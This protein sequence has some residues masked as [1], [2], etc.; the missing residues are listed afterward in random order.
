MA[1]TKDRYSSS[2]KKYIEEIVPNSEKAEYKYNISKRKEEKYNNE[3]ETQKVNINEI[4]EKFAPDSTGNVI[5]YKYI[6]EGERYQVIADMVAGSL[7]IKDKKTNQPIKLDGKPGS[8]SE[9]HFKIKKRG[10]M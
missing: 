10:E 4:V 3:W 5:G 8:R 7:R 2:S 9:T 1:D 6:F